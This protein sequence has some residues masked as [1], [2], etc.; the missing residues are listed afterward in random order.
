MAREGASFSELRAFVEVTSK[1][2]NPENSKP[3]IVIIITKTPSTPLMTGGA[4][5]AGLSAV[6]APKTGRPESSPVGGW[7]RIRVGFGLRGFLGFRTFRDPTP[8]FKFCT[9]A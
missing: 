1:S 2:H 7:Y 5:S 4:L 6:L 9:N 8:T 3:I